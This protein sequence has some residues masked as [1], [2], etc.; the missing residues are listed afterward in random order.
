[1][2][3]KGYILMACILGLQFLQTAAGAQALINP[4]VGSE[5]V[6][7]SSQKTYTVNCDMVTI[8]NSDKLFAIAWDDNNSQAYFKVYYQSEMLVSR[9]IALPQGATEPDIAIAHNMSATSDYLVAV[10]YKLGADV[11]LG[12]YSATGIAD[13]LLNVTLSTAHKLNQ[14]AAGNPHVDMLA[15]NTNKL[16]G[17]PSLHKFGVTWDEFDPSVNNTSVHARV[18][19]IATPAAYTWNVYIPHAL[20]PDVAAYVNTT[21]GKEYLCVLYTKPNSVTGTGSDLRVLE[22]ELDGSTNLYHFLEKGKDIASG[23]I[24]CQAFHS[25]GTPAWAVA[26][27]TATVNGYAIKM[28][29]DSKTAADI[30]TPLGA[31]NNDR[32]AIAAGMGEGNSYYSTVFYPMYDSSLYMTSGAQW[33]NTWSNSYQEVNHTSMDIRSGTPAV[34]ISSAS[35]SGDGQLVAWFNGRDVV[36]KILNERAYVGSP[37]SV[38]NTG[39]MSKNVTLYPNPATDVLSVAGST[40]SSYTVT[41]VAGRKML[42]GELNGANASIS[43]STLS[44]G[45]YLLQLAD[46]NMPLRFVKQ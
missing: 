15:D 37:T 43:I 39:T 27:A 19:D 12:V 11:Y 21:T 18:A 34:A 38:M 33:G 14:E 16:N 5:Q 35:N 45:M 22:T 32:P 17:Y 24:E 28:Y 41:D 26:A 1:M 44:P 42:S 29:S 2:A 31:Y 46:G 20:N 40:A 9:T 7:E 13:G 10:A 8:S 23:R 6:C 25:S 4:T 36:Y 30:S 3:T